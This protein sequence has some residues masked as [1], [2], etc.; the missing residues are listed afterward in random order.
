MYAQGPVPEA[1]NSWSQLRLL[2][3]TGNQLSGQ[4]PAF[5][6]SLP[7]LSALWLDNNNFSSSVPQ[8]WCDQG[9]NANFA[10]H[11]S[12][13]ALPTPIRPAGRWLRTLLVTRQI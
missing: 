8:A 10:V 2:E 6:A 11:L 3:L 9:T 4:M 13:R 12:V 1:W 7:A 5:L